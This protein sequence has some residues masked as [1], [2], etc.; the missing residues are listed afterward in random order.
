MKIQLILNFIINILD[1]ILI[2]YFISIF[3]ES[4]KIDRKYIFLLILFQALINSL[5][6]YNFGIAS[7]LGFFIMIFFATVTAKGIFNENACILLL[8]ILVSLIIMGMLEIIIVSCVLV[9]TNI[10]LE[11]LSSLNMYR[12]LGTCITKII[13]YILV[14]KLISKV[15]VDN[16][17]KKSYIYQLLLVLISNI[18]IIFLALWFYK[19]TH[20]IKEYGKSYIGIIAITI[21]ISSIGILTV[22]KKIINH[23]K[24]EIE[25]QIKE[26]EY[27]KQV[28]YIKNIE[29]MISSLKAE[30]HDFNHHLGCIYGLINLNEFEGAKGYINTLTNEIMDSN[31]I[32][33]VNHPILSSMLNIKLTK[34]KRENIIVNGNIDVPRNLNIEF[35]DLSRI[36]GNLLD[37][38]IE[39]CEGLKKK[40]KYIN[41]DIYIKHKNLL[42]KVTNS[43]SKDIKVSHMANFTTK[44]DSNNHGFGLR[45]IKNIVYK[46]HGIMKYEDNMEY[47]KVRIALP[48]VKDCP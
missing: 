43:K 45:N 7:I 47:F 18:M 23:A 38:A 27:K 12:V 48:I 10:S 32:L 24:K 31:A 9:F 16:F 39:A 26:N 46:Y 41:I 3:V 6:N 22:A 11:T 40:E 15:K 4:R 42:I 19:Y 8:F 34:A 44:K 30:R 17:F 33:G 36:I 28:F 29:D 14:K 37:N 25:W 5:I 1:V 13:Y 20:E 2:F 35:I 21:L